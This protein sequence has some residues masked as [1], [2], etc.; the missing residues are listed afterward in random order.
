MSEAVIVE[1]V[2]APAGLGVDDIGAFEVNEAFAP[3]PLAWL[4]ETGAIPHV[5]VARRMRSRI[6]RAETA[7]FSASCANR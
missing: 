3:V 4:A 2:L 1:A 6:S 5:P 7:W